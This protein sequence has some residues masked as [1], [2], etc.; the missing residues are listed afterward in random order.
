M[1][2]SKEKKSTSRRIVDV[3]ACGYIVYLIFYFLSAIC[4]W[5]YTDDSSE[6]T[7]IEK[8]QEVFDEGR[9]WKVEDVPNT[10]L[11][12]NYIHVCNPDSIIDSV[13]EDSIN[14]VLAP[15]KERAD[16]FIVALNK[17]ESP[18]IFDFSHELFNKWGIGNAEKNNGILVAMTMRPHA[19]FITTGDGME[20]DVPD[21]VCHQII[22]K[23]IKPYFRQDQYGKG[24]YECSKSLIAHINHSDSI[25]GNIPAESFEANPQEAYSYQNSTKYDDEDLSVWDVVFILLVAWFIVF[26]PLIGFFIIIGYLIRIFKVLKSSKKESGEDANQ[27]AYIRARELKPTLTDNVLAFFFPVILLAYIPM[28]AI[29]KTNRK[30]TRVC[31]YCKSKMSCLTEEEEDAYMTPQQIIEERVKVFDYDVWYCKHCQHTIVGGYQSKRYDQY[32]ECEKCHTR[33]SKQI[34][35]TT[36]DATYTSPGRKRIT[37]QCLYCN[38]QQYVNIVLPKL[39]HSTGSG[40]YS[41]GGYSGGGY[42][43]GGG[44]FGG[45]HSSGGGAGGSW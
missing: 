9:I 7:T 38:H 33:V 20:G 43:G 2:K 39:E 12:S 27:I 26:S 35:V 19:V 8:V 40:G 28:W 15:F 22:E 18:T 34:L 30:K 14:A 6:T 36:R 42:S 21:V 32:K 16:I 3:I 4:S 24:L 25:E 41:G 44:S 5:C 29:Y 17:V 1:E 37:Y 31:P 11:T 23:S 10:R 45:G 13:Y